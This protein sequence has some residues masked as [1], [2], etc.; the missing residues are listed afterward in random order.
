[1]YVSVTKMIRIFLQE[2]YS[3]ED[4]I[5]YN[6]NE[7]SQQGYGG[8]DHSVRFG[9]DLNLTLPSKFEYSV[10]FKALGI[11]IRFF[12]CKNT[13][14]SANPQYGLFVSRTDTGLLAGYRDSNTYEFGKTSFVDSEYHEYKF[15]R[16][17]NS[18]DAYCDGNLIGTVSTFTWLDNYHYTFYWAFWWDKIAYVKEMKIKPL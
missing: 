3:I 16:N 1:M 8:G 6:P 7:Y 2:T 14:V 18:V 9:D 17:G 11:A 15:I 5:Y 4:T 13:S 10:K 12:L